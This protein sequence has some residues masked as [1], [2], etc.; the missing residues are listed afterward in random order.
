MPLTRRQ[1]RNA[2]A[3][4][5]AGTTGTAGTAGTTGTTGTE[6]TITRRAR[7][8]IRAS[9]A[10]A[11][12]SNKK[13]V[14]TYAP[15]PNMPLSNMPLSNMPLP[16]NITELPEDMMRMTLMYVAANNIKMITKTS[17]VKLKEVVSRCS[18]LNHP[19]R[20][21]PTDI[22]RR[23]FGNIVAIRLVDEEIDEGTMFILESALKYAKVETIMLSN[24]SFQNR[25]VCER[26]AKLFVGT[27]KN[28][29]TIKIMILKGVQFQV[30]NTEEGR[31]FNIFMNNIEKLTNLEELE[32]SN[33]DIRQLF[34]DNDHD[35][36]FDFVL[37]RLL[38]RLRKLKDF[39]FTNNIIYTEEYEYIFNDYYNEMLHCYVIKVVDSS[40]TKSLTGVYVK[41][42]GITGGT[43]EYFMEL[44]N[45]NAPNK[46]LN[47][48]YYYCKNNEGVKDNGEVVS[49]P[50]YINNDFKEDRKILIKDMKKI[51]K[52]GTDEYT[53]FELQ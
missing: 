29:G 50:N 53:V 27:E 39:I 28:T 33:F 22:K 40:V 3:A 32:I 48:V 52:G 12:L 17:I 37:V 5:T 36:T 2:N 4:G 24:I 43:D 35:I 21:L 20:Q 31:L 34:I 26:F 42:N 49:L 23:I 38:I 11:T 19:K 14:S 47:Q 15:L 41:C 10:N 44:M 30:N 16:K 13:D 45:M 6:A 51:R 46:S 7:R 1:R 8:A 9:S 25:D 18:T